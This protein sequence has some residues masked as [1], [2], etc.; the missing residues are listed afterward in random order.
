MGAIGL[1]VL[2][3]LIKKRTECKLTL[4]NAPQYD[5]VVIGHSKNTN[6]HRNGYRSYTYTTCSVKVLANIE[7]RETCILIKSK[8]PDA[9]LA[10]PVGCHV[11]IAGKESMFMIVE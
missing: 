11:T 4:A 2:V 9:D 5:A 7:G 10:Y 6:A 8:L 1:A 3:K